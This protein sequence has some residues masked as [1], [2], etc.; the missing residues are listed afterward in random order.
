VFFTTKEALTDDAPLN[1]DEKLY[2]YDTSKPASDS[3]NLTFVSVDSEPADAGDVQ[4][5]IGASDDGHYVYF[6]AIGQLVADGPDPIPNYGVYVWHD[7][8]LAYV[9]S[10]FNSDVGQDTS[11]DFIFD[12]PES[13]VTPDGT[14][15]LFMSTSSKDLGGYDQGNCHVFTGCH[16]LYVYNAI[17]RRSSCA[18]C[19]PSG[20][21]AAS[22]ATTFTRVSVGGSSTTAARNRAISDDG[23]YVFFTTAE[24][25]VPRDTNGKSDAYEYDAT[26]GNVSLLST[27]TGPSNS[28]F[29]NSSISGDSAFI[30][31]REQLVGRDTDRAYDLYDVRVG[32]GF[33]EPLSAPPACDGDACHGVPSVEPPVS[34]PGSALAHF[35]VT[36]VQPTTATVTSPRGGET[37]AHRPRCKR[38]RAARRVNGKLRCVRRKRP[39]PGARNRKTGR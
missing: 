14:H 26:T 11:E 36:P 4:G 6:V 33:P 23:R 29:M 3:H 28:Y 1:S 37:T 7:G 34:T 22:D 17:D 9:G 35:P 21:R 13:R 19:N 24:A 8:S 38:G 25:L 15:L 5:V 30:L 32:G 10:I 27:G 12:R 31:T 20:A 18:S 2:M 16:E 39:A